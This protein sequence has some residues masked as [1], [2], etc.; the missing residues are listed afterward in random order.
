MTNIITSR[1]VP[2][3]ASLPYQLDV[4]LLTY[5][6]LSYKTL[7]GMAGDQGAKLRELL[8]K[9]S[10]QARQGVAWAMDRVVVVGRKAGESGETWRFSEVVSGKVVND[11]VA[12]G[13]NSVVVG[14]SR[15][16]SRNSMTSS[17]S[18]KRQSLL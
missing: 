14:E 10:D 4:F 15:Q 17:R 11:H 18:S 9:A 16:A 6:E 1:H 2:S 5:E 12:N 13:E 3:N 8:E 7:D